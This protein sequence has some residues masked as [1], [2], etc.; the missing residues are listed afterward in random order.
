M[1]ADRA[2]SN[3]ARLLI[4]IFF[5]QVELENGHNLPED[6]PVVVV[7]NHFNGL[8]DGL[9]LMAALRRYPRFLGKSTLF[10]I[11]P[12][13]PFLKLGGVIPVYR[14]ID[15]GSGA[16][17]ASAFSTTHQILAQGGVVAL[18]PEGISHDESSLQPL[19]TGAA[20]IALEAGFEGAVEGVV[21]VA[22]GLAYDAKVR[23]RSR[24]LVRIGRPDSIARW[25]EAYRTDS[26]EAVRAF[27]IEVA[28]QLAVVSPGYASWEQAEQVSR[29][30][31]VVVRRRTATSP[32]VALADQVE[33]AERLAQIEQHDPDGTRLEELLARFA[34]YEREL[35]V[36]GLNDA[37]VVARYP[38][39]RRRATLAW[40]V[41][42]IL[43]AVPFAA[44]GLA[45]HIVP[46]QIMK[47][48]ATRP[49]NEGI[50]ATVKLLGCFTLFTV[51]Y[52]ALGFVVGRHYGAWDGLVVAVASPLCGY[53][54]V[55]VA[56][57]VK[58]I[59]GLVE[60]YRIIRDHRADWTHLL[61]QRAL[62]VEAAQ[63]VLRSA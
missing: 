22:V 45:V 27:T 59:G 40:A 41:V 43:A 8:V 15:G 38:W 32:D 36:V 49:A 33:V 55:R 56:E 50:K 60:G 48:L 58:R 28:N 37:Q 51:V 9:L 11:P 18:F 44:A 1:W 31:E 2:M 10:K 63:T 39:S 46:F 53:V 13:W 17:N 61:N 52:A 7:A 34:A 26:H 54:T 23:F 47:R 6:G 19:R 5:R 12:L 16:R 4:H 62:V 20:R 3:F 29:V 21:T 57:R 30:A 24:A 42:K 14:A 35:I 25:S